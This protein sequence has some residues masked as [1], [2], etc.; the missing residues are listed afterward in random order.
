MLSPEPVEPEWPFDLW[1]KLAVERF[2]LSPAEF[3]ETGFRDWRMLTA[4]A[5]KPTMTREDFEVLLKHF[6][7]EPQ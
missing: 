2:G 5:T 1:L 7:D 4:Q 3:W 6:P